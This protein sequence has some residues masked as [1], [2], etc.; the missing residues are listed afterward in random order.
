MD[1][2]SQ[3][4]TGSGAWMALGVLG[5]GPFAPNSQVAQRRAQ[6]MELTVNTLCSSSM[7][8]GTPRFSASGHGGFIELSSLSSA[9]CRGGSQ[10]SALEWIEGDHIFWEARSIKIK[11]TYL[12]INLFRLGAKNSRNVEWT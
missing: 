5:G 2:D 1:S 7:A 10:P 11:G 3:D 6:A 4:V 9:A 8:A 12:Q